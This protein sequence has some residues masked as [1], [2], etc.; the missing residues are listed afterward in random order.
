MKGK[1]SHILK[2]LLRTGLKL[3]PQK[4]LFLGLGMN[5]LYN[6]PQGSIGGSVAVA[7]GVSDM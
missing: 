7:V 1:W 6:R 4:K 5:I 2:F 3:P